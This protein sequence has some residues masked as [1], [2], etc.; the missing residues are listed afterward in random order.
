MWPGDGGPARVLPQAGTGAND[1]WVTGVSDDGTLVGGD[2]Y[3]PGS[4]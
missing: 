4:Q 2:W 3:G 1:S